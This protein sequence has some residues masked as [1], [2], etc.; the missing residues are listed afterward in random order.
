MAGM[1][2]TNTGCEVILALDLPSREEAAHFLDRTGLDIPW[3]KIGLQLF[4]RY[5]PQ[6]VESISYRGTN[7]FLDVKLHDIPN[8]VASAIRSLS[9]LPVKLVTIHSLGGP[10]MIAAAVQA[11]N[12]SN[13]QMKIVAVT[14]LTSLGREEMKAVGI[15]GAPEKAVV[16][17]GKMAVE[18]G[19]DGLVC[20]PLEVAALRGE[21]GSKPLLV[22]PG[23]R[24]AG[25][26]K[27]DQERTMTPGEAAAAGASFIVVGRPILASANPG[28]TYTAIRSE[29]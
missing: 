14:V 10:E 15:K 12:Q 2:K 26:P 23:I 9:H 13:P 28:E 18:A 24:P 19:A 7:I 11:R 3:V 8:T 20:S 16:R 29:L 27:G 25:A 22:V 17:L 6:F 1:K 5:G 21:L 4:T